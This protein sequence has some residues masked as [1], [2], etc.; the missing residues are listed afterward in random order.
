MNTSEM[1]FDDLT[2]IEVPVKIQGKKY[3]LR[4]ASGDAAC[5]WRNMLLKSTKLGPDGRPTSID[6]MA[7]SDPYLVSL[8]LF[9]VTDKGDKAVPLHTIRAWPN[10]VQ[11]DLCERA[12]AISC[13]EEQQDT[14]EAL[15]EKMDRLKEQLA[16]MEDKD[17]LLKKPPVDG[18]VGSN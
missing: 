3:V 9:E 18:M 6:G 1:N 11:K 5:K 12:K 16:T 13:L 8:C 17:E 7:D 14:K 2:L 10:R 4:E 15:V